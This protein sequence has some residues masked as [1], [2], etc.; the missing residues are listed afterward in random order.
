MYAQKRENPC[1][2]AYCNIKHKVIAVF[3]KRDG[4]ITVKCYGKFHTRDC[5]EIGSRIRRDNYLVIIG[6]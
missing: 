5:L 1:F 2:S 3:R 4:N 6:V